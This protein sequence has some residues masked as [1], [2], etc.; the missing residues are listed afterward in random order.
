MKL[1]SFNRKCALN[2]RRFVKFEISSLLNFQTK[3]KKEREMLNLN[4]IINLISIYE[5]DKKKEEENNTNA[6]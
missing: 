3:K 1:S 2:V 6:K 4:V 5:I